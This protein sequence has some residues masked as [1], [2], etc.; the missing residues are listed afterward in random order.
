MSSVTF[1]QPLL[2]FIPSHTYFQTLSKPLPNGFPGSPYS[3]FHLY[4]P[5]CFFLNALKN[6]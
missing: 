6:L 4:P 5:T 1:R 3:D 2:G